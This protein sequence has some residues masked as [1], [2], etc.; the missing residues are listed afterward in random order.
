MNFEK[1][2]DVWKELKELRL[3]DWLCHKHENNQDYMIF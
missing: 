3:C 2:K 1:A